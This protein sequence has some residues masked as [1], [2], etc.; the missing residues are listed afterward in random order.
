MKSYDLVQPTCGSGTVPGVVD[1]WGVQ[2]GSIYGV[3]WKLLIGR[4][5]ANREDEPE[6]VGFPVNKV[7][8]VTKTPEAFLM[9]TPQQSFWFP[10]IIVWFLM[11][12][13]QTLHVCHSTHCPVTLRTSTVIPRLVHF[14]P[15]QSVCVWGGGALWR[16]YEL[17]LLVLQVVILFLSSSC[18]Q[19][20]LAGPRL[21]GPVG[22][23]WSRGPVWAPCLSDIWFNTISVLNPEQTFVVCPGRRTGSRWNETQ[24]T[25]VD[26]IDPIVTCMW[27][28]TKMNFLFLPLTSVSVFPVYSLS[29]EWAFPLGSPRMRRDAPSAPVCVLQ[30]FQLLLVVSCMLF[31]WRMFHVFML[32]P[33]P[34]AQI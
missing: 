1:G 6:W 22:P 15:F 34:C 26:S 7:T 14:R 16:Q 19:L 4:T 18:Y 30:M 9:K 20:R 17:H 13:I 31:S 3:S 23:V 28:Y 29:S 27:L 2:M 12:W 25:H 21:R 8:K 24:L 10:V 33:A 5:C 11:C 32:P